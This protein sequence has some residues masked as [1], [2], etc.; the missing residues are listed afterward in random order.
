MYIKKVRRIYGIDDAPLGWYSSEI[1]ELFGNI[2]N[3][4]I[5]FNHDNIIYILYSN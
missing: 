4:K 5:D 3:K 2:S 1:S